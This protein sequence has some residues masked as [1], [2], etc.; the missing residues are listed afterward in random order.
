MAFD[1]EEMKQLKEL[2]DSFEIKMDQKLSIQR[3]EIGK[4]T[5]SIINAKLKPIHEKLDRFFKMES[6][7]TS[8]LYTQMEQLQ[9]R[10]LVTEKKL[11]IIA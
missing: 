11:G 8:E 6:E 4:D 1:K 3:F 5:K 9:K 10:V 2:F 7:D